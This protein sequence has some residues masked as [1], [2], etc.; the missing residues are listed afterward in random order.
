MKRLTMMAAMLAMVLLAGAPA[1]AQTPMAA[2]DEYGSIICVDGV[3][4]GI[5]YDPDAPVTCEV[6]GT[7]AQAFLDLE[8]G[9][10]SDREALDPDG[11]G[12]ACDEPEPTSPEPT[13][14][15]PT[16]P[17]KTT[18]DKPGKPDGPDKP[19]GLGRLPDTGGLTILALGAGGLLISGGLLL[20]RI[21]R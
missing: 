13:T 15:E 10:K 14:P 3:D 7:E 8:L 11:N 21:A 20:H 9:S 4:T 16:T 17:E 18:L 1:Q 12:I 5:C 6:L 19:T 2:E